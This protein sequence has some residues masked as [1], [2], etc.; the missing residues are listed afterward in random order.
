MFF[1]IINCVAQQTQKRLSFHYVTVLLLVNLT[2]FFFCKTVRHFFPEFKFT[3][4]F[5]EFKFFVRI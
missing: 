2:F 1:Y 5:R 3:V 4:F